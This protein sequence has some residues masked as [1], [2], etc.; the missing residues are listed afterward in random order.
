M[1]QSK[2]MEVIA[3]QLPTTQVQNTVNVPGDNGLIRATRCGIQ[4]KDDRVLNIDLKLEKWGPVWPPQ[5]QRSRRGAMRN[6]GE[7][8]QLTGG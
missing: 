3:E 6:N 7:R 5:E 4:R 8:V 1:T 2:W